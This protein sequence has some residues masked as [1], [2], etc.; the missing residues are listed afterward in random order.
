METNA[1][2]QRRQF[3]GAYGTGLWSMTE[4]CER[5]GIS[6]PTGY[7]WVARWGA[8]GEAGLVARSSAPHGHP[9]QTAAALEQAL[10]AARRQYGWGATKLLHI[11]RRRHPRCAWPTRS[12]V[13]AI[14]DRHGLLRKQRRT[15][16]WP[17]AGAPRLETTA[18]NQIWPADFKGHFKTRDGA[19]CY[20]LTVTD[21]FSRAVLL[22]RAL[23][24]TTA[25]DAHAAFLALFREVGLPD[26][27]RTDNGAP[28]ASSALHGLTP[29]NLWWMQL[30]IVHQRVRPGYPQGNGTHER[31]HRELKREATMPPAATARAQQQRFDAFRR[32]YN[33]ER[34]H[35]ALGQRCP[36]ALWTPSQRPY[37]AR[38]PA[39]EYPIHAEVRRVRA[40]GSV[41][42]RGHDVFLSHTLA[43]ADVALEE[44]EDGCWNILFYRTVLGRVDLHTGQISAG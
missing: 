14:L 25:R 37:P 3:V 12:T 10:V 35:E 22:C 40:S 27:I 44:V 39:P 9:Q 20:P 19:Y 24:S 30:G 13:N 36:A 2:A 38:I 32:R 6:R 43:G 4:L 42:F 17:H 21:H 18:A 11:L 29:L 34:P 41:K 16:R 15:R 1:V 7:T 23:S 31:M 8:A 28:F 5:F 33:E 26:A